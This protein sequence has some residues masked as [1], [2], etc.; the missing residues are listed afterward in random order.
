MGIEIERKFLVNGSDWRTRHPVIYR[1]GYLNRDKQRTV[2]VRIAGDLAF[3]TIKGLSVGASRAEF[4]Y[5]IP[6]SDAAEMLSLCE[7]PLI[8][9]KRH[10]VNFDDMRWEIDEFLG[11][12]S[13]L[14]VAEVELESEQQNIR[15]PSWIA[16]EVTDDPRYFNSSLSLNPYST[17]EAA[18]RQIQQSDN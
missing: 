14:V 2:R 5:Q 15:L 18:A 1:Q 3:L 4:E 11:E 9:K 6:T 13:G 17:W 12:N 10:I 8:E 16:T 7:T